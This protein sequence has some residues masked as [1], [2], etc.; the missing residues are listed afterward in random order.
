MRICPVCHLSALT[1]TPALWLRAS[2]ENC[3][4][5][6][7]KDAESIADAVRAILDDEPLRKQRITCATRDVESFS[8]ENAASS[9]LKLFQ[10][11]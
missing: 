6:P 10:N 11:I 1:C 3:W 2:P 9:M 8:W 7:E 5:V 4:L